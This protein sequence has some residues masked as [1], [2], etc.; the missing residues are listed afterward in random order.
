[1]ICPNCHA[2]IPDDSSACSSCGTPILRPKV[3]EPEVLSGE[4]PYGNMR[5]AYREN[6]GNARFTR[7][8]YTTF[9]S[10]RGIPPACLPTFISLG[11]ALAAAFKYGILAAIG[12]LVFAGVG[13]L[14]TF[15]M[16]IRNWMEG[17]AINP[18]VLHVATWCLCWLL[19]A[20]PSGDLG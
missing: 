10:D 2:E 4:D 11:L 6:P 12:F 5:G 16:T 13:R 1:M 19:V 15:F 18:W 17:R 20:W 14:I 9:P 7:V 3:I 8:F